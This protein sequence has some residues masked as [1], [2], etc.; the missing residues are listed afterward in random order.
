M[1]FKDKYKI[2]ADDS[3]E[4]KDGKQVMLDLFDAAVLEAKKG[5]FDIETE[6]GKKAIADILKTS[7]IKVKLGDE[8]MSLKS[9]FAEMQ[10]QFDEMATKVNDTTNEAKLVPFATSLKEAIQA[11]E[12]K[13]KTYFEKGGAPVTFEVKSPVVIGV[14]NTINSVGSDSQV[15][16]SENTGIISALRS[17]VRTYLENVSVGAIG[18]QYAIWIEETDEEG[19]PIF[20]AEGA[21]K[22]RISVQYVEKRKQVK[23]IGV[24]G[25]V[26]YELMQDLPQLISYIQQ[27]MVKRVS[28]VIEDQLFGGNDLTNNL[29][30]LIGY[31]TAFTGGSLAF[32]VDD[33]N[34][35]DVLRAIAL[36]VQESDGEANAVFV[37]AGEIAKMDVEKAS[38]GH[39]IL[40]PFK[41]VNGSV[42]AGVRLI[43]TTE[44]PAGTDFLG[45]DL[46][47]V[48]VRFREGMTVQVGESG[49]DFRD[50]LKT[51]KVEQRLVQFVSAND[52]QV[53]VKGSFAAAKTA[54]DVTNAPT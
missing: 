17:R 40:P 53:L 45:G 24:T 3:Q 31:A 42:V 1:N 7:E 32:N 12:E 46:S 5:N 54:L 27:N 38:D 28:D 25:K 16:I 11:N 36:Q 39:Y 33:P 30:G 41:A 14:G 19:A 21:E 48:N 49:E 2:L 23:K 34:N 9:A 13:L 44:L 35:Y 20:I 43:S 52:T 10:K 18:N 37:R 50:N 6:E 22:T 4:V 26:T 29:A 15:T 47:V 51:I 8:E